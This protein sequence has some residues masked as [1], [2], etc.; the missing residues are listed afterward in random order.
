MMMEELNPIRIEQVAELSAQIIQEV[1][2]LLPERWVKWGTYTPEQ[3]DNELKRSMR[4]VFW[5]GKLDLT[6]LSEEERQNKVIESRLI[7]LAYYDIEAKA[8]FLGNYFLE[9]NHIFVCFSFGLSPDNYDHW[10]TLGSTYSSIVDF[11]I[12]RGILEKNNEGF[13]NRIVSKR[14]YNHVKDL[15]QNVETN[16]NI[17]PLKNFQSIDVIKGSD[18]ETV[19]QP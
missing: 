15:L 7:E 4:S 10:L 9:D 18:W 12:G 8:E 19:S 6:Q 1:E 13:V 2:K 16:F 14:Q 5:N 3:K 17:L 11:W